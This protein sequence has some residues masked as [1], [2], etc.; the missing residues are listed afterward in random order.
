MKR[1]GG[2][3][4]AGPKTAYLKTVAAIMAMDPQLPAQYLGFLGK[5]IAAGYLEHLGLYAHQ[6]GPKFLVLHLFCCGKSGSCMRCIAAVLSERLPCFRDRGYLAP[7]GGA[8]KAADTP[9]S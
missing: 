3:S 8:R 6:S 5:G 2:S 1:C 9:A 7:V 4:C